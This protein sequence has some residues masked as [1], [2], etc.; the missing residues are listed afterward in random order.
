MMI[1]RRRLS[2]LLMLP[3]LPALLA[4]IALALEGTFDLKA[5]REAL[6]APERRALIEAEWQLSQA[7]A[8]AAPSTAAVSDEQLV[9]V[10]RWLHDAS[11]EQPR[12][13]ARIAA[14]QKEVDVLAALDREA[15]AI[16]QRRHQTY[17]RVIDELRSLSAHLPQPPPDHTGER[18]P[19]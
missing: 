4:G 11:E 5:G 15:H 13:R 19:R 16:A 14:L 3:A 18:K 2:L 7:F 8:H 12:D 1:Q 9:T 10:Q 17:T 6:Y